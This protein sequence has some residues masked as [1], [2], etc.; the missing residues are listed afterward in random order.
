MVNSQHVSNTED[1]K[2]ED[3]VWR[4]IEKEKCTKGWSNGSIDTVM[5][6]S[7]SK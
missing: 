1:V 4:V 5:S 7:G 2:M 6:K 3:T